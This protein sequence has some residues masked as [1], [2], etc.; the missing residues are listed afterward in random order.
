MDSI[1]QQ[2]TQLGDAWKAVYATLLAN[3]AVAAPHLEAISAAQ[4]NEVIEATVWWLDRAKAPKGFAPRFHLAK[5]VASTSLATAVTAVKNVQAGQYNYLPTLVTALNQVTSALHTLLISSGTDHMRELVASLGTE[6]S[7]KL[8]LVDTAQREL[9]QKVDT[10]N[11]A[12]TAAAEI[13]T[14][15]VEV[16][17]SHDAAAVALKEITSTQEK[18]AEILEAIKADEEAT[19][20]FKEDASETEKRNSNSAK[21]LEEQ[22]E[23]LVKLQQDSEK[24][25][26]TITGL[27]PKAASAG[28]AASFATRVRQLEGAK[29][30]WM[31]LFILTIVI[32]ALFAWQIV[33]IPQANTEQIWTHVLHRLP[34]ASPLIWLAW[35]S[36]I[37][38][39][40]TLR[41][42]EDYAFKEATSKAFEGYRSHMEHLHSVDL[43]E[44][45]T[46]MTMLSAKTIEILSH[47]PLRILARSERDVSPTQ[48]LAELLSA[49][50]AAVKT[51]LFQEI[52]QQAKTTLPG[53]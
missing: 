38:Y 4:I 49:K 27:L 33:Q 11:D 21:K 14:K 37:Q 6:L 20:K 25:S 15:A 48:A 16:T 46:A 42:Q 5:S 41:V 2:V 9:K 44:G 34:L 13:A 26:E 53:K 19:A 17:E 24:Q 10:L 35:F 32:L 47:E 31:I 8:S 50:A 28:L 36:A 30:M 52:Q 18:A 12:S 39:G 51:H 1:R 40:N 3:P 7:E 23:K 29:W 45:N 43:E 22:S